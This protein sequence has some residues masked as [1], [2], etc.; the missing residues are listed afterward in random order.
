MSDKG[1]PPEQMFALH[2][3]RRSEERGRRARSLQGSVQMGAVIGV[4]PLILVP[5]L[6]YNIIAF[7]GSAF[8]GALKV[9]ENFDAPAMTI[10]MAS[11]VQWI[12]H[13][14]DVL[15]LLALVMLFVELLK[16]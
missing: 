4:F 15:L 14:G 11:N 2:Q 16:S 13:W 7:G 10:P 1:V 6:I 9:R 12:V 5:V 3:I 8:S